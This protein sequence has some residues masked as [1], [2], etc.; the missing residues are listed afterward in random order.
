MRA[1]VRSNVFEDI[2]R[3][4]NR[5]CLA[6]RRQLSQVRRPSEDY[7]ASLSPLVSHGFRYTVS[8]DQHRRRQIPRS[9][10]GRWLDCLPQRRTTTDRI[11]EV[12]II[13]SHNLSDSREQSGL[14]PHL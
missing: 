7:G 12:H 1:L 2:A 11:A 4:D 13:K 14:V 6:E 5:F 10:F 8:D 3:R 9:L